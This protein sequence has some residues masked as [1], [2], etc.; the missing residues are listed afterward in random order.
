MSIRILTNANDTMAVLYQSGSDW[1][2]GRVIHDDRPG[3]GAWAMADRFIRFAGLYTRSPFEDWSDSWLERQ[4][5]DF[6]A[7]DWVLCVDKCGT[8]VPSKQGVCGAC[9]R[10]CAA[11][12]D[13]DVETTVCH[14]PGRPAERLCAHCAEEASK[15]Q[16]GT[17]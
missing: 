12:F 11:C 8:L 2:F 13:P 17:T 6:K 15:N 5:A 9:L 16:G 7:Q 10:V 3:I 1:A 4:Y 14:R